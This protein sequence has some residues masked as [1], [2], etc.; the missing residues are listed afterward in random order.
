MKL[1][2]CCMYIVL[3]TDQNPVAWQ[4]EEYQLTYIIIM[5]ANGYQ[6]AIC[7]RIVQ[8]YCMT[9]T[10]DEYAC[11]K[12]SKFL[13]EVKLSCFVNGR[14]YILSLM[15]CSDNITPKMFA[16][17]NNWS[18]VNYDLSSHTKLDISIVLYRINLLQLCNEI[19]LPVLNSIQCSDSTNECPHCCSK[20]SYIYILSVN[21]FHSLCLNSC[22]WGYMIESF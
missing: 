14:I 19:C 15:S 7:F 12:S 9:M 3:A 1:Y 10:Y 17:S 18:L 2:V 16:I 22:I 13:I 5:Q 4:L 21:F 11:D 20:V 6:F 8:A